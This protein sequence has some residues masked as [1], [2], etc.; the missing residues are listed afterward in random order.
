MKKNLKK[1]SLVV[2]A[3]LMALTVTAQT[4]Q[5]S[6]MGQDKAQSTSFKST[7]TM[8]SSG[9]SYS[10]NPT[11]NANGQAVFGG[12][13]SPAAG[14][15]RVKMDGTGTPGTPSTPGQGSQEN[16]FPIGDATLPMALFAMVF[17]MV[18]AVRRRAV[19]EE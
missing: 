3:V 13:E 8:P 16:Q 10:A 17:A 7:A 4:Y 1:L 6:A 12:S 2:M 9:S 18:I 14:P 5:S 19:K 11:I 15:R